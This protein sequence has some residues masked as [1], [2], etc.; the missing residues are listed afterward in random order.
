MV[1]SCLL[2]RQASISPHRERVTLVLPPTAVPAR[3]GSPASL[4]FTDHKANGSFSSPGAAGCALPSR[5]QWERGDRLVSILKVISMCNHV[6]LHAEGMLGQRE[7][8]SM[9]VSSTVLRRLAQARSSSVSKPNCDF[10]TNAVLSQR[11]CPGKEPFAV[12]GILPL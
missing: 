12:C 11:R 8:R 2:S 5:A 1:S 7:F 3:A 9:R 6:S 10:P 4:L